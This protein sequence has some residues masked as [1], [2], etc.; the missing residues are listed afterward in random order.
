MLEQYK[1]VLWD[2]DGVIIDSMPIR[3][4]GFREILQDFAP[5]QVEEL[6]RYHRANGGLSRF[7]K[8]RYFFEVILH[9]SITEEQV[10]L[11]AIRFSETM[12]K[13]L[14]NKDLLIQDAVQYIRENSSNKNYH[15]VSA[16]EEQELRFLCEQ[17]GLAGYFKSIHGSPT[18]K[19]INVQQLLVQYNYDEKETCLIGD[20]INDRHAAQVNDIQFFGYNSGLLKEESPEYYIQA[21]SNFN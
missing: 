16:S 5:E 19:T 7:I 21:F 17:L 8:I 20:S 1:N 9:T 11:Y 2:F 14:C 3:E 4:Q 18:A 10:Q 13:L 12:R 15:V 6:V